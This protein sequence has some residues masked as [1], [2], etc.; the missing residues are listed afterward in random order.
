MKLSR[1]RQEVLYIGRYLSTK[2]IVIDPCQTI[3]PQ[4][5]L[6]VTQVPIVFIVVMDVVLKGLMSNDCAYLAIAVCTQV[7]TFESLARSTNVVVLKLGCVYAKCSLQVLL[8]LLISLFS[9]R[10]DLV[11][12]SGYA[13]NHS[14]KRI[15]CE[16]VSRLGPLRLKAKHRQL[17][18]YTTDT[19]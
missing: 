9:L 4:I 11:P 13:Q 12:S 7:P 15:F 19:V 18:T 3:S 8:C 2:G 1:C 16:R 10:H 17:P 14:V 5:V 6:Y